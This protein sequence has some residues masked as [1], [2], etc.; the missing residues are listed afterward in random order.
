MAQGETC[1]IIY[2]QI[3]SRCNTT[4]SSDSNA[5]RHYRSK[6]NSVP[7]PKSSVSHAKRQYRSKQNSVPEPKLSRPVQTIKQELVFMETYAAGDFDNPSNADD[8]NDHKDTGGDEDTNEDNSGFLIL[9]NG[10]VQCPKCPKILSKMG[11]AKSHFQMVHDEVKVN[12]PLCKQSF[13]NAWYRDRHIKTNHGI[14]PKGL[15]LKKIVKDGENSGFLPLPNGKVQ[16]LECQ[17]ILSKMGNA[18]SH[19]QMVHDEVNVNCQVCKQSFK[20]AWYRDRHI[21]TNHG[22]SA[23]ALGFETIKSEEISEDEF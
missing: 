4:I 10:K 22:K 6:H 8:E 5:K 19:F 7:E 20:N 13:K 21:K 17:K 2:F 16:C 9:S 11:N 18:K 3:C 15:D 23:R 12:C 14:S 1:I